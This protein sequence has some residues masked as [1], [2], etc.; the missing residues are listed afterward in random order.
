MADRRGPGKGIQA[1]LSRR[2]ERVRGRI[3]ADGA[4]D[5]KDDEAGDR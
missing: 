2:R 1:L 3:G 5:D 4:G